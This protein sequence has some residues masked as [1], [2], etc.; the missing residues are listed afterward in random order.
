MEEVPFLQRLAQL[1]FRSAWRSDRRYAN[2]F[3]R[4]QAS[5][6]ELI[7]EQDD[8]YLAAFVESDGHGWL[9]FAATSK[10]VAERAIARS[11]GELL[12]RCKRLGVTPL[13]LPVF[14]AETARWFAPYGFAD[15]DAMAFLEHRGPFAVTVPDPAIR[16]M[17]D[18]DLE[19]VV[20][21][22]QRCFPPRRH[23]DREVMGQIAARMASKY[24][25]E[26]EG[27]IVGFQWNELTGEGAEAE[28]FIEGLAVDPTTQARG[29]GKA[30]LSNAMSYF[31]QAGVG[32]VKLY[33]YPE[34]PAA[35]FY[36]RQGFACR[37]ICHELVLGDEAS[38]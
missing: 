36:L 33:A 3:L 30:L 16:P 17:T 25:L 19:A 34:S 35:A 27:R 11:F 26:Q 32:T 12:G 4:N 37:G 2:A 14:S 28:G 18:E 20:E 22:N 15:A 38:C 6:P 8:H 9:S 31:A 23:F 10:E 7:L 13:Q 1:P 5:H 21:V 29:L 24:V